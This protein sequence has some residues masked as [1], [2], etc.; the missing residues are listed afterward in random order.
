MKE[1]L[2]IPGSE[3]RAVP[4]VKVL[5]SADPDRRITVSIYTRQNPQPSLKEI[6]SAEDLSRE[7]PAK[8]RYP[9]DADFDAV[10]GADPA[11]LKRVG[12]WAT[13]HSLRVV[14]E[15]VPRRR[16]RVEGTIADINRAFGLVEAIAPKRGI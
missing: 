1:M 7:L 5:G 12:A 16:I 11:D 8:R 10:Y 13:E 6:A 9:N 14:D 2:A 4:G 15:S 3:R